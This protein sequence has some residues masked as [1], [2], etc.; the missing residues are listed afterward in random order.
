M[1]KLRVKHLNAINNTSLDFVRDYINEFPWGNVRL[2]G[3]KGS[4][5]VGK[6]TLLLQYIKK[7]FGNSETAL[8]VSLDDLYFSENR[9][10][11]LVDD[12][13][14]KGGEYLFIDEVHKYKN[15]AIE[16]KNIYDQQ[17]D[18]KVV[19]T[20]SSLLEILNARADLSRRAVVFNM[21]GLSF[22]EF[23]KYD[24]NIVFQKYT[25]EQILKNHT[26]IGLSIRS[27]Y[28][29]L[30]EFERYLKKGYFPFMQ[31]NPDVYHT[32]VRE[33]VNMIMEIEL[34]LMRA[35]D[36]SKVSKM[37]Q[38]LYIIAQSVP[39]K[40]NVK[41]LADRIG[42]SRNLL[43]SYTKGLDDANL[44]N[45]LHKNTFGIGLLQK[46]DKIYLENTNLAYALSEQ[47]PNIGN[48]RETFFL[49]QVKQKHTLTYPDKGDFLVDNKYLFE[50]G[51]KNK[52]GKQIT[53]IKNAFVVA[54]DI[55]FGSDHKI[56]LWLFGF[57]Y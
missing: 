7:N 45:L 36:V 54:D 33:I 30:K 42:I 10:V 14:A 56:P 47:D 9:L 43:L 11:D 15:W 18:L 40:P 24:S 29:V 31:E 50:V 23:L 13:V 41:K 3:I 17:P 27:D 35:M 52:T 22:R 6:T 53:G 28:K 44:I 49:N 57:L 38:L 2:M 26:E 21:Q 1:Q 48:V 32:K 8:Y 39:F 20:G 12:F 25:L 16:I 46:P 19:F 4:R 51:G 5:G 34:P 37:K 55:E